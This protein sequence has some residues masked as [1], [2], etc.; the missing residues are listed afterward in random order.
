MCT[1]CV[2]AMD[3]IH[4]KNIDGKEAWY[5]SSVG[6]GVGTRRGVR[7]L[8]RAPL[9]ESEEGT[10]LTLLGA[11]SAG[12]FLDSVSHYSHLRGQLQAAS[13]ELIL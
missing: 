11:G 6:R 1:Q 13:C 9:D 2:V 3:S 8:F 5:A 4:F 10:K 12:I 7:G